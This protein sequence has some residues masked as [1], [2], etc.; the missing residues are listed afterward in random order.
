MSIVTE[1]ALTGEDPAQVTIG[2]A[3]DPTN[4]GFC[5]EFSVNV[6][7]TVT[8]SCHGTG[9]VLDIYRIGYYGGSGWRKVTTL[10]NTAT[11]QPNPVVIPDT[12]GATTCTAW[13]VTASW[14]VPSDATSG[15]YV[16]VL[17][18]ATLND[19]SYIPFVVRN[20]ALVADIIVKTSDTT[21]GLAYNYYGTP[22]SPFTG[23]S[24]YGSGGPVSAGGAESRSYAVTYHRPIITRQGVSQT[25][26]LN[27]ESPLI[28]YLE[29][30]GYNVKYV[31][32][33]DVDVD[34]TVLNNSKIV[35]SSGHDEYW[36]DGMRNAFEA[37]RD[38]G[39]H[40]LFMSGN[41]V[42]WRTRFN[43]D[44][45]IMYCYKDTLSA[46]PPMDPITWTGTWKDTRWANRRPENLLTG[47]DFRMNGINH[48]SPV[49]SSGASFASHPVWRNSALLSA[50]QTLTNVVGFEADSM[51]PVQ[52]APS[53]VIL[54]G[55]NFNIDGSYANDN[56]SAYTGNG[57][58]V[59]GVVSQRYPSGGVVVGFGTCQ[60][61]W[62]LDANHDRDATPVAPAAQ[63]FTINLLRDLGA[64]P[65]TLMAGMTLS[66]PV[67]LD[68]YGTIPGSNP[69]PEPDPDPDPPSGDTIQ[70]IRNGNGVQHWLYDYT[71]Q[72]LE[73]RKR[74]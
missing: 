27:A 16:G 38:S 70:I 32:S 72:E 29:R 17:R 34:P 41:E 42:F 11:S 59:W 39:K 68:N 6:G 31:S 24:L 60:W 23:K 43:G 37:Y 53:A 40:M 56:G 8:F 7:E 19:A 66:A 74:V 21:W 44:R 57:T 14:T 26:W 50:N 22:A 35:I 65:A 15:L 20:D 1:N 63:Q 5:R 73:A 54:A 18:K 49:L 4:L 55:Q 48:R 36:S 33:K 2:G 12:N 69:D 62:A 25:Y 45:S 51:L 67:S 30:N 58:L 3:G 52:T 10:T 46:T 28:R 13:S 47:T 64:A 71:G 9:T 61:A